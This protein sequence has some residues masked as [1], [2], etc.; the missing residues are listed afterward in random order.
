[1][2]SKRTKLIQDIE[3][4]GALEDSQHQ[5]TL[6][7][8]AYLANEEPDLCPYISALSSRLSPMFDDVQRMNLLCAYPT[9]FLIMS[10]NEAFAKKD[11]TNAI[12]P[13]IT[14][15]LHYE[16]T[17]TLPANDTTL[18]NPLAFLVERAQKVIQ[19]KML[20]FVGGG[21]FVLEKTQAGVPHAHILVKPQGGKKIQPSR[22]RKIWPY[23]FHI[24]PV[25]DLPE[26]VNYLF[27]TVTESETL[28]YR[29][30]HVLPPVDYA[31]TQ[32]LQT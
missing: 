30:L 4:A 11:R 10:L 2:Q 24:K 32:E 18:K 31:S 20:N 19:S 28:E 23:L 15:K 6:I 16:I 12:V 17:L 13:K 21:F 1:M 3:Q 27:K 26:Y 29:E 22:I 8:N 9:E 14:H 25:I 5:R 7:L